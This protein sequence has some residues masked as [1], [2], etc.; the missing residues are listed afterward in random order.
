MF[1]ASF[2]KIKVTVCF[3]YARGLPEPQLFSCCNS[4]NEKL[5]CTCKS[6]AQGGCCCIASRLLSLR[7]LF[8]HRVRDEQLQKSSDG[9]PI[10]SWRDKCGSKSQ[11]KESASHVLCP[12][13]LLVGKGWQVV[14]I[15]SME[16]GSIFFFFFLSAK[17]LLRQNYHKLLSHVIF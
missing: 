1:G 4:A 10:A 8:W 3:G 15:S 9:P 16:D 14:P 2:I 7:S 12:A 11:E 5:V 17:P 6:M 13:H